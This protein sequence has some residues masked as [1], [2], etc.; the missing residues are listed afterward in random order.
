ME[1]IDKINK[2]LDELEAE[3]DKICNELGRAEKRRLAIANYLDD[4]NCAFFFLDYPCG[5]GGK[6]RFVKKDYVEGYAIYQYAYGKGTFNTAECVKVFFSSE[7]Q[8]KD[9][10][11]INAMNKL[12]KI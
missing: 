3:F 9:S 4:K 5:S 1:N 11:W 7:G 10:A 8:L 12:K 2:F 6:C